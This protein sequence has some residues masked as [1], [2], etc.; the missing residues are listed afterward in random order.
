MLCCF[1]A[2]D[3]VFIFCLV[4]IMFVFIMSVQ[5]LNT[6]NNNERVR[7]IQNIETLLVQY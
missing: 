6:K 3:Y 5:D 2:R 1:V 7:D 4:V